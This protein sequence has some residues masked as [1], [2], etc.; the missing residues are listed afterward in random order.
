MYGLATVP[1]SWSSLW[2]DI[3]LQL[4][5]IGLCSSMVWAQSPLL[6]NHGFEI[7]IHS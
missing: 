2:I 4:N 5:D 6:P 7:I 1:A 3:L